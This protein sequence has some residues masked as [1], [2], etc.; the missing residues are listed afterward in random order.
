[1]IFGNNGQQDVK[2]LTDESEII[3]DRKKNISLHEISLTDYINMS[4]FYTNC[5]N[6]VDLF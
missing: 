6:M 1:M 4:L 3:K 5:I 2:V